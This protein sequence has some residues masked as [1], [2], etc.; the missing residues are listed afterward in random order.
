MKETSSADEYPFLNST[1]ATDGSLSTSDTLPLEEE[2][3]D[4]MASSSVV[5]SA[6]PPLEESFEF[7]EIVPEQV[8]EEEGDSGELAE[9]REERLV[10]V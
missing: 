8:R 1:A 7:D 4:Q 6:P 2:D 9:L 10:L 3:D 5:L